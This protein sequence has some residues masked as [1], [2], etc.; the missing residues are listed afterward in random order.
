MKEEIK[1]DLPIIT[2]LKEKTYGFSRTIIDP[3]QTTSTTA[4]QP[5][6]DTFG[7]LKNLKKLETHLRK[8]NL[9]NT[10]YLTLRNGI[11]YI[12]L[13]VC[14][15][16]ARKSL[17]TDNLTLAVILKLKIL[18]HLNTKNI[19][20]TTY[21][22]LFERDTDNIIRDSEV[23][24]FLTDFERTV[25]NALG[26][27]AEKPTPI[28]H[29]KNTLRIYGAEFIADKKQLG[30]SDK[31]LIKYNQSLEYLELYYGA[32]IDLRTI[33]YKAVNAFK[34]FLFKLP[35]RW[36]NK[37]DLNTS[38]IKKLIEKDSPILGRYEK[39]NINTVLEVLKRVKA[40]FAYFLR[41]EY[42][43]VNYFENL[44]VMRYKKRGKREFE[45][46]E[47]KEL[48]AY[49]HKKG[50]KEEY[51]FFAFLLM[52]GLRRGE[53]LGIP[54][55]RIEIDKH[56]FEVRGTKTEAAHRVG[57]I[58]KDCEQIIREQIEDKEDND[59]L[60]FNDEATTIYTKPLH[61]DKSDSEKQELLE[62]LIGIRL[63]KH[64]KAVVGS[65]NK[66]EVDIHS[67]RKN[68]AQVLYMVEDLK[69][70]ELQTLIGH[71]NSKNITDYH[72]LR[73]KRDYKRLKKLVD[74]ADFSE[75]LV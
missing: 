68:Y 15:K 37:K 75:F 21:F 14:N 9:Y 70:S 8:L 5:L 44:E 31:T 27:T 56:I 25:K 4:F 55:S 38:N 16:V 63:N 69:E 51:N 6:S 7:T 18:N 23:E 64:I 54:L 19:N 50:L 73:G 22:T 41:N 72:Y 34:S 49:C 46:T 35:V 13:R 48:F 36:K 24:K 26:I 33:N 17:H 28:K 59:Y 53:A 43:A 60:F 66:K 61:R 40:I 32:D 2:E 29:E 67:L 47:L 10:T 71:T 20:P 62:R 30:T 42:I 52:S 57:I 1:E 3:L 58:H 65:D 12:R 45:P 11:Y 74:L 39:A